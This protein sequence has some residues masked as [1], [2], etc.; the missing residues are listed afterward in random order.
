MAPN[1]KQLLHEV[2]VISG[3]IKVKVS[4]ISRAEA[5]DLDYL[6]YHK[7]QNLIIVLLYIVFAVFKYFVS[8]G[9]WAP[10]CRYQG[11]Q[12]SDRVSACQLFI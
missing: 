11:H 6:G 8:G 7:K 5:W 12:W 1:L 9:R 2:F 4:V 3:I 10:C